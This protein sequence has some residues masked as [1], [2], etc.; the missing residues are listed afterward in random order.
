NTMWKWPGIAKAAFRPN[1]RVKFFDAYETTKT[2]REVV[3][4]KVMRRPRSD[5]ARLMLTVEL[6]EKTI[7]LKVINNAPNGTVRF[8]IC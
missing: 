6:E 5:M 8:S 3:R 7:D 2:C 4:G 1:F